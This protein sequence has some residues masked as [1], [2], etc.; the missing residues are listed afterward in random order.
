[1]TRVERRELD[2]V[3]AGVERADAIVEH[4]VGAREHEEAA[5]VVG[6]EDRVGGGLP[7]GLPVLWFP[8]SLGR[9]SGQNQR[10]PPGFFSSLS[11]FLAR[12]G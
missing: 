4:G 11:V 10:I 9:R 3:A 5:Q 1:M 8:P 6:G 2:G 12:S 7:H